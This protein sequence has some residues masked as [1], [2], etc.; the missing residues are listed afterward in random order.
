MCEKILDSPCLHNCNVQYGGAWEGGYVYFTN[1]IT[2]KGMFVIFFFLPVAPCPQGEHAVQPCSAAAVKAR[3]LWLW[4]EGTS[5][6]AQVW[7][8]EEEGEPWHA[9]RGGTNFAVHLIISYIAS[10]VPAMSLYMI[11]RSLASYFS[12]PSYAL[13]FIHTY[14]SS[15]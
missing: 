9:W 5:L 3:P 15:Y 11:Y 10:F 12:Y 4:S 7:W 2:A 14:R 1:N 6:C 13:A 8:Q